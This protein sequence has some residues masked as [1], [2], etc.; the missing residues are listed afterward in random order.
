MQQDKKLMLTSKYYDGD[1]I[2]EV[3]LVVLPRTSQFSDNALPVVD[4]SGCSA[5]ESASGKTS[6][7]KYEDRANVLLVDLGMKYPK[8]CTYTIIARNVKNSNAAG[9][10]Y[11]LPSEGFVSDFSNILTN[12]PQSI[13]YGFI[14]KAQGVWVKDNMLKMRNHESSRLHYVTEDIPVGKILAAFSSY[15]PTTRYKPD[16][17]APGE[18]VLTAK[19][20]VKVEYSSYGTTAGR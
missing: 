10:I 13:P 8:T 18:L 19:G 7:W 1:V 14:T 16:I 2:T 3:V 9:V 15:G 4:E 12:T 17:V 5:L 20:P 6:S 11:I